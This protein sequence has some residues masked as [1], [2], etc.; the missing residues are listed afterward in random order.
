MPES[1]APRLHPAVRRHGPRALAIVVVVGVFVF[2]LPRIADWGSVWDVVKGLTWGDIGILAFVTILNI[3]TFGPPWMAAL[4]GLSFRNSLTVSLASTAI[5]NVA[6]GGD[7]VGL[8][9]TFAMLRGWG[10]ERA[11][12]TLALVVFTVWNQL[13]NVLFPVIAVVLLALEGQSNRLLQ[14][15][16]VIGGAILVVVLV[17]FAIALR[18]ESGAR[19]VGDLAQRLMNWVMRVIRRRPRPGVANA[20]VQFREDS[21]ELLRSRWLLLTVTTLAGHLTVWLV[22]V[23]SLYVVGVTTDEVSLLESFAAWALVRLLTAIPIT[24]GGLGVVELGLTGTLVGFGGSRDQVVAAVLLY[25]ALTFLPPLPLGL[26]A[27]LTFRRAHPEDLEEA[28]VA[29]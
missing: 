12:A 27:G 28:E 14:I 4:P 24:P 1:F 25:R 3:L 26:L 9:T 13:V 5:A 7:A 10:F 20:V 6:P 29:T 11:K 21:L 16:A 8:A 15:A 18:S 22:L 17:A 23:A 19:R 2:V